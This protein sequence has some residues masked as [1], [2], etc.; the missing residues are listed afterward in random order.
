MRPLLALTMIVKDEAL[1]LAETLDSC[2]GIVDYAVILDTGSTD[3]T[4]KLIEE[5]KGFPIL[6]YEGPFIDFATTRNE[7]L[8]IHRA[9]PDH[10]NQPS[11]AVFTLMLSGDEVLH[12]CDKL[13]A[14]LQEKIDD[15]N[16][17]Y[18]ITLFSGTQIWTYPRILRT[19]AKWVYEGPIHEV[20]VGPDGE[21]DGPLLNGK[22]IHTVS[23]HERRLKRIRE[24][25][26]PVLQKMVDDTSKS[27]F[28]RAHAMFFLADCYSMLAADCNKD[29]VGG[30]W[31]TFQMNAMS[32]YWRYGQMA[33]KSDSPAH[34][35]K[36]AVLAYLR[37]INIA[38][39]IGIYNHEEIIWRISALIE[40]DPE[41]P[42]LHYMLAVHSAQVD[43][44]KGFYF[45][46]RAARVAF[47]AAQKPQFIP[48]DCQIEW[49]A[50]RI[51]AA[52]ARENGSEKSARELAQRAIKAGGPPEAFEG[53]V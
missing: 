9:K 32:L 31:L 20:P 29:E 11:P 10:D 41:I 14:Q 35:K 28:E 8:E 26:F 49:K 1:N 15:K 18:S 25:D 46:E 53:F 34:D 48:T 5:F 43:A 16:G 38:E 3:G 13:R 44:R 6:L 27:L 19:D 30:P 7:V 42:E 22:I 36:K 40:V 17:A 39:T 33:E 37:Y 12:N 24:Y 21:K 50:L 52:C 2:V 45:A 23:D 4:Q 51:A 47:E